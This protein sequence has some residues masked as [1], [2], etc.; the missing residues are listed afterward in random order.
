M[1]ISVAPLT[2]ILLVII[3]TCY[4]APPYFNKY[5]LNHFTPGKLCT[6]RSDKSCSSYK[7]PSPPSRF[8]NKIVVTSTIVHRYL[9][10][11]PYVAPFYYFF[12]FRRLIPSLYILF[13]LKTHIFIF[14]G[15]P[16]W[17]T[18]FS[19]HSPK[20]RVDWNYNIVTSRLRFVYDQYSFPIN[21]I[22]IIVHI[23]SPLNTNLIGHNHNMLSSS[24]LFQ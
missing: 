1:Y 10:T 2:Q 6:C 18:I 4:Q 22:S 14:F 17:E 20:W 12:S 8:M 24:A 23:S 7:T 9:W 5:R 11:W 16:V 15:H 13:S 21:S 3:I 19:K